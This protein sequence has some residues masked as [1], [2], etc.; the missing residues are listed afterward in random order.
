MAFKRVDF[1]QPFSPRRPYLR[2]YVSSMVV[3]VMRTRPWKTK[4]QAVILTSLLDL[5]ELRTP[6]VTRSE[7]PCLSICS[8][9]LFTSN[10]FLLDV[11]GC[12]SSGSGFPSSSRRGGVS[13]PATEEAPE[14]TLDPAFDREATVFL[15]A[16]PSAALL[17]SRAALDAETMMLEL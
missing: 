1:P 3:S 4:E 13:S 14:G 2:P 6:V 9:N 10:I 12:S 5:R 15:G 17:A 8:A 7:R 11:A 16:L